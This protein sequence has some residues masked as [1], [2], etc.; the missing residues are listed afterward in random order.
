MPKT[1]VPVRRPV[2]GSRFLTRRNLLLG[3]GAAIAGGAGVG[4]YA[5]AIA[6]YAHRVTRY[7]ITPPAWPDGFRLKIAVLADLHICEPWMGLARVEQIVAETNDLQPDVILLLGDYVPGVSIARIGRE[8]LP[9]VWAGA[10][11]RLR[12][13][14]GVHAILG[15]HDW[16]EDASAMR[17]GKGPTV[18]HQVLADAGITVHE[19]TAIRLEKRQGGRSWPFWVAGLGDQWAFFNGGRFLADGSR[20]PKRYAGVDDLPGTLS[21]VTDSAPLIFMVHEPDIFAQLPGLLGGQRVQPALTFAG[22]T[23]GGQVRLL[24]YAPMVPS[25]YGQRYTYGHIIEDNRHLVVSSGLGMSGIPV[26][27]GSPPE[28]VLVELGR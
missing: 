25:R 7:A 6:P 4:G 24:G 13:P 18:S 26:R 16:W 19:N 14:Q 1:A 11:G 27:F 15:N 28:I 22:H 5:F 21:R 17:T 12:A 8:V 20:N 23:H 10:L 9:A 3:A 2:K